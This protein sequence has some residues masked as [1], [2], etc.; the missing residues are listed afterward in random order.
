MEKIRRSHGEQ[1]AKKRDSS[2]EVMNFGRLRFGKRKRSTFSV[3][4]AK[5]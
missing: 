1:A 2:S 5:R 3:G 4:A